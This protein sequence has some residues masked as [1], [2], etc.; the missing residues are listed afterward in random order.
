[1]GA[2]LLLGLES[3][4]GWVHPFVE[5]KLLLHDNSQFQLIGGLNLTIG[6]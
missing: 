2:N 6:R 1:V 4:T 5:G 3:R